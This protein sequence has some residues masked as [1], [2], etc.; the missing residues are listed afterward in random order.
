MECQ[1]EA[2][3][4]VEVRAGP[5]LEPLPSRVPTGPLCGDNGFLSQVLLRQEAIK[6]PYSA[7]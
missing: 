3:V 4:K 5:S 6:S 7:L 2:R 1:W